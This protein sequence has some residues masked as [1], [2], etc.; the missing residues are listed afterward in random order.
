MFQEAVP[1][2][3]P[4]EAH[5]ALKMQ[6]LTDRTKRMPTIRSTTSLNTVEE[7]TYIE[8][9]RNLYRSMFDA[10]IPDPLRAAEIGIHGKLM[11]RRRRTKEQIQAGFRRMDSEKTVKGARPDQAE[12]RRQT[13]EW[14]RG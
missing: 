9:C 14:P 7:G 1:F 6:S 12:T 5:E 13:A 8:S 10:E 2:D 11:M 4:D 3:T